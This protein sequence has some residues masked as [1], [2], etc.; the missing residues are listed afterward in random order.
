MSLR[1]H[2]KNRT[3]TGV[4]RISSTKSRVE[5]ELTCIGYRDLLT[6]ANYYEHD[7]DIEFSEILLNAGADPTIELQGRVSLV[8]G[9]ALQGNR[10]VRKPHLLHRTSSLVGHIGQKF[11]TSS[12][13]YHPIRFFRH[14]DLQGKPHRGFL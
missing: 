2:R 8:F 3:L 4:R 10:K 11:C 1:L 9:M 14:A 12:F 5:L 7:Y 6:I 13:I